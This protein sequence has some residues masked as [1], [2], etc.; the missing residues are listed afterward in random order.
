MLVFKRAARHQA[1]LLMLVL[2]ASN[3]HHNSVYV[4]FHHHRPYEAS[5]INIQFK[6]AE[7][8]KPSLL[9][10][11]FLLVTVFSHCVNVVHNIALENF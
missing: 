2:P 6:Q 11:T 1:G 10:L 9:S 3:S 7:G 5:I 8:K 4:P